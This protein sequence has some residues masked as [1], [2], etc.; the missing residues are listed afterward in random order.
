[1]WK[2]SICCDENRAAIPI[3]LAGSVT[4]I[5][6]QN[7]SFRLFKY[8]NGNS[9]LFVDYDQYVLPLHKLAK[10]ENVSEVC[11]QFTS[12][13]LNRECICVHEIEFRL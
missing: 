3:L 13:D 8:D 11:F 7:P 4:P 6:S 2:C 10:G 1:M 9:N 12:C 5:N